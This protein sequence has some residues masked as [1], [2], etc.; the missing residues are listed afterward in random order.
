[1][2]SNV[3]LKATQVTGRPVTWAQIN[4]EAAED[5]RGLMRRN[6]WAAELMLT[7]ITK[8]QPGGGGVVVCSRETMRELLGCSMPTIERALRI[9]IHEGWVQRMRIGGAY[10]LAINSRVAWV[11]KRG[12]LP[13]AVFSATVIA[14]RAEQDEMALCP[15]PQRSIPVVMDGDVPLPAGDGQDPPSQPDLPGIDPVVAYQPPPPSQRGQQRPIDPETG[16]IL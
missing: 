13:H 2:A 9:I 1:M 5:L 15:P 10:A 4:L 3:T 12:A 7:L 8:M 6:R 14:S 16:E 11:D